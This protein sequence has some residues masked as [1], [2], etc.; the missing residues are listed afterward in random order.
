MIPLDGLSLEQEGDDDGEHGQGD[1]LLD[2]LE[3]HQVEGTAVALEADPVRRDGQAVLEEG[4]APRKQD[5]E[6]KRPAGGD[7]HL[8]ELEMAVPGERHEDV[9]AYEHE[10]GPKTLHDRF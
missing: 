2:D 7:F 6:D 8:L 5:D 9:R 4:D 3:L 10:D 1:D